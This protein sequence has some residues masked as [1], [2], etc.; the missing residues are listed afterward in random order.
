MDLGSQTW[1]DAAATDASVALLP[2]GS[3]EQHGPHAPLSTDCLTAAAVANRAAAR[4]E[5]PVPVAPTIPIGIAAEHR[6]FSGTLWVRPDTFRSY[7]SETV[8]SLL[9][10]GWQRV[11][12]VNGHGGNVDALAEVCAAISRENAGYAVTFTWF[13]AVGAEAPPMGHAGAIETAA[14]RQLRP[15]LV[16]EDRVPAAAA[17]AAQR[18]GEW[19]AGVNLAVDTVE[20][21]EN[22]TVGDPSTTD[23]D[24]GERFLT[25]AAASLAELIETVATRPLEPEG[26]PTAAD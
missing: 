1:T 5:D 13:D 17:G 8:E 7:V 2:V 20:F 9:S 16:R 23:S 12:V 11:V 6:Q 4:I 19:V 18:W 15:D 14:I 21:S 24:D 26:E 22:G 10:H 25:T 3:T